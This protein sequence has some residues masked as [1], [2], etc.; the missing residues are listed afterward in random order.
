MG[1]GDIIKRVRDNPFNPLAG[2]PSKQ[3]PALELAETIEPDDSAVGKLIRRLLDAGLDGKGPLPSA[4]AFARSARARSKSTE[5]AVERVSRQATIGGGAGGFATGLGGFV[6]MPVAIPVNLL[7]FYLQATRTVGAIAS[8]RGYD[9]NQPHIRTAVLLSLVGSR[10]DEILKTAGAAV[11]GGALTG[12]ALRR[13]PPSALMVINKAVGVRL[14]KSVGERFL[15]RLGRG[16]P[17]AGGVLGGAV[18]VWMMRRILRQAKQE[19][20]QV[21]Q[22]D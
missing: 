16:L 20:P 19:F 22:A 17:V 14:L 2:K 4:E 10:S 5:D 7:E 12:M 21:D 18:D 3:R 15:T 1:V 8:L 6:T 9:V 13:L 11:P